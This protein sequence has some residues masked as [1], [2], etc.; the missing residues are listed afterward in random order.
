MPAPKKTPSKAETASEADE[1]SG[2]FN[3]ELDVVLAPLGQAPAKNG[4]ELHVAIMSYNS[5]EPKLQILRKKEKKGGVI[6][7]APVGR[8]CEEDALAV[9]KLLG[10]V[11]NLTAAFAKAKE[12]QAGEEG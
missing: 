8:M 6:R 7:H 1:P 10:S 4:G 5:G 12:H 2:G 9:L 3:P 11:K